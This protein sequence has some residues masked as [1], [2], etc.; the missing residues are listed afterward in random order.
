MTQNDAEVEPPS[1][2][3]MLAIHR[4]D[5]LVLLKRT[6]GMPEWQLAR[7]MT[8]FSRLLTIA[9]SLTTL[10]RYASAAWMAASSLP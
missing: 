3:R 8:W 1:L 7:K 2:N 6:P 10:L 9:C 4:S 5:A